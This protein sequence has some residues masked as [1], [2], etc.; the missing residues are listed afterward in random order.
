MG[1]GRGVFRRSGGGKTAK[2]RERNLFLINHFPPKE[3]AQPGTVIDILGC[4]E[5]QERE[6]LYSL[7]ELVTDF[8]FFGYR[9]VGCLMMRAI[10]VYDDTCTGRGQSVI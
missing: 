1:R 3:E 8:F 5:G 4:F 10:G 9:Q 2:W 7:E 6:N